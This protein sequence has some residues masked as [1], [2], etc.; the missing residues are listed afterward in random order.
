MAR[1]HVL[2]LLFF[3]AIGLSCG[4]KTD[5]EILKERIDSPVVHLY[6][7]SKIAILKADQS[8]E[9]KA[10]RDELMRAIAALRGTEGP[11]G[12]RRLSPRDALTLAKALYE[13]RAEGKEL[14]ESGD[15]KG[16]AP[17]LPKLFKPTPELA[18][19]LDL[20]LE[21]ALLL[22]GL[23]GIKFHPRTPAPV[24]DEILLYEAWM[25][26]PAELKL[27]GIKS[28]AHAL[29]AV[30]YG[31]NELC[32]LASAEAASARA[33]SADVANTGNALKTLSGG[34]AKPSDDAAKKFDAA[35]RT[36]AHGT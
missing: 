13:L 29:K 27:P 18:Q 14:L 9:A 16:M 24:P 10:A 35:M 34:A 12:E 20:N 1:L 31:Q 6:L 3:A 7:A 15:E 21:H 26:K 17:I 11:E 33:I 4:K 30:V 2:A 28:P 5:E 19:V 23:L 8:A 32:D 36:L 25:T 22:G